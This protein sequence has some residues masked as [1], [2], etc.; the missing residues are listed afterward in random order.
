MPTQADADTAVAQFLVDQPLFHAIMRGM[1]TVQL[2]D[3][4]V[5][6]TVAQLIADATEELA[7]K[8]IGAYYLSQHE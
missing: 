2:S 5:V 1:G 4:T 6:K 7:D 8:D 3:G